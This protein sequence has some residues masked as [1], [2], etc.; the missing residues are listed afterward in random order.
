V[1]RG[2]EDL[3]Q[4]L[5]RDR[6]L[7]VGR[8][9]RRDLIASQVSTSTSRRLVLSAGRGAGATTGAA[10]GA[11]LLTVV[12]VGGRPIRGRRRLLNPGKRTAVRRRR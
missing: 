11:A 9:L 5:G 1:P 6:L 7:P 10:T 3:V 2:L 8:R 4:V 12:T